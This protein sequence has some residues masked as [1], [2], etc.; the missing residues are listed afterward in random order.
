M[1]GFAKP[2]RVPAASV[3]SASMPAI[4]GEERLVPPIRYVP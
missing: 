1:A 2:I 3:A 4:S